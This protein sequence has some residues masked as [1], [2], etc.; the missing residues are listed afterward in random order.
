MATTQVPELDINRFKRSE[1]DPKRNR[2]KPTIYDDIR[3]MN[4]S[5]FS[6]NNRKRPLSMMKTIY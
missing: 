5:L 2:H 1:Y 6:D 3:S 4:N